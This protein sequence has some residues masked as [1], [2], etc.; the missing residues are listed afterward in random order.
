MGPLKGIRV[1]EIKG[2]GPA[3]Y[4]GMLLADMGADVVV[5]ERSS[6]FAGIGIPAK[7]DVTSRSK[8][9]IALDIK[10]PLGLRALLRLVENADALIEG[11]RPGVAERLGFGPGACRAINRRLVYGRLTGWGQSGPLAHS[12]GHDLNYIAITGALAAIGGPEKP[13]PPL[14]LVGDYA[15]GSLFLV[16]GILAAI[17]EARESGE[18]QVV[19]AAITDGSANLMSVF[20]GFQKAGFWNTNRCDNLLDGASY[21][22]DVYATADGKFVSIAP[23]EPKFYAEFV[24]RAGLDKEVFGEQAGPSDWRRLKG[25]LADAIKQKTQAEW[26][27]LLEGSDACFAPVLD[28]TEALKHPHNTERN[29]Y[30][31]VAGMPQPAPAPRFSRSECGEPSPPHAEGADYE[32]VLLD[33]GFSAGDIDEMK[34][35]G[36]LT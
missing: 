29:T 20:Y 30:I 17:L 12:A 8:R 31:D 32:S 6:N 16:I 7:D 35:S 4:A 24:E 19:D 28:F 23:L 10:H 25:L 2:I 9:S 27:E 15:G 33:A 14:N 22:Y 36:A 21:F 5:V 3:P 1:V 18:G 26:C 34:K 13:I 11:F